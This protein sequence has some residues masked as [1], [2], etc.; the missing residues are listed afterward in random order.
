[1]PSTWQTVLRVA[2]SRRTLVA[3]TGAGIVSAVALA[4]I[5]PHLPATTRALVS[6]DLC[7]ITFLL[8]IAYRMTGLSPEQMVRRAKEQDQGR[9][10][11]LA[12]CLAAAVASVAAIAVELRMARDMHGAL[13]GGHM[14]FAFGTVAFSWLFVHTIFA[15]HYAHEYYAPDEG[16][17]RTRRREGLLFPGDDPPDFWDFVHFAF[18]IGVAAQTAD[19]AITTK[20]LRRLVTVHGVVAFV[21][22]TVVLALSINFAAALLL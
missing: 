11:I 17:R 18:V 3:S 5:A 16:D 2:A 15:V 4:R 7:V 1:M 13:K 19:V 6:W 21:F 12:L 14:A 10:A 8:A 9:Y 22:N 20:A